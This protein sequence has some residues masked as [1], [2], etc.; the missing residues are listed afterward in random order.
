[1][2][3]H[4]EH[5][6]DFS[7]IILGGVLSGLFGV[8]GL[9]LASVGLYGVVANTVSQRTREIGIRTAMGAR[10][11]DVLRL[12]TSQSMALVAVG[13]AVGGGT[14]LFAARMLQRILFSV[15][16]ADLRTFL[17]VF[18]ILAAVATAACIIPARRAVKLDATTALRW[19]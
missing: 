4:L 7:T 10:R 12:V 17:A 9:G 14:G 18:L 15:D 5:G 19:E 16:P 13:A 2:R 3:E 11:R 8:L 6:Y 1:M